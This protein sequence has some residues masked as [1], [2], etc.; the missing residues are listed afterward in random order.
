[1]SYITLYTTG[2]QKI[3]M[4]ICDV[5]GEKLNLK[6]RMG[7]RNLCSKCFTLS[8]QGEILASKP[9]KPE[10]KKI[11]E[12]DIKRNIQL[13]EEGKEFDI[14]LRKMKEYI[15]YHMKSSAEKSFKA[16]IKKSFKIKKEYTLECSVCH[17][18]FTYHRIIKYCS[19]SCKKKGY[20]ALSNIY[21][22]NRMQTDWQFALKTRLRD[23]LRDALRYYNKT[24]KY[25]RHQN[26]GRYINY[27]AII[28]HL[29]P[30]PGSRSLWHI[31]HIKPLCTFDFSNTEE[32]K[33]A[34]APKNL[35]WL[36]AKENLRKGRW[37]HFQVV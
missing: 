4:D 2:K 31:D 12:E 24:G 35:R 1:M 33:K 7:Y 16:Q 32:I 10:S 28:K 30:C 3:L 22:R 9:K 29:G 15:K 23:N 20:N 36:S 21:F 13:F 27:P 6:F 5:C 18:V 37:N 26:S 11:T 19:M 14:S 17:K 34:F 25:R 8:Q